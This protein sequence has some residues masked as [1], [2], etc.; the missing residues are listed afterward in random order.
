MLICVTS[1]NVRPVSTNDVVFSQCIRVYGGNKTL[2]IDFDAKIAQFHHH[3]FL[4]MCFFVEPW[5]IVFDTARALYDETIHDD[6][7]MMVCFG[8][9]TF[10]M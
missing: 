9:C 8:L 3:G 2:C 10:V 7:K 1:N 6:V 5:K 4:V